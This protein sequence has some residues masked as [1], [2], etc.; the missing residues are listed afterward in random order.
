[1]LSDM[2]LQ[3]NRIPV[4]DRWSERA[5]AAQLQKHKDFFSYNKHEDT[6]AQVQWGG[7]GLIL[8]DELR[9]RVF[10][11]Q[12]GSDEENLGWWTWARIQCRNGFFLRII[13]A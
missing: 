9:S 7:T 5:H 8:L 1:M 10:N 4:E 11:Q 13:S 12:M 3:W 6:E 2:C